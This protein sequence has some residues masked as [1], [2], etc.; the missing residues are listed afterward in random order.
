MGDEQHITKVLSG[1][2]GFERV[3]GHD[4]GRFHAALAHLCAAD[5][6]AEIADV[7]RA[8]FRRIGFQV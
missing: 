6:E 5:A 2:P 3:L 7:L 8:S 1:L 4:W